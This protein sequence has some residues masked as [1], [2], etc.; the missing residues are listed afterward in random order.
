[1]NAT[2][3]QPETATKTRLY[4]VSSVID[5]WP[6]K[7]DRYVGV[8]VQWLV[9][10]RQEPV[11]PYEKCIENYNPSDPYQK[12]LLDECFTLTEATALAEHLKKHHDT[13]CK[14]VEVKLPMPGGDI[15]L[16][17]VTVGG[18]CDLHMLNKEDGY[19]LPFAVYGYFDIRQSELM[20]D[21]TAERELVEDEIPW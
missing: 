5:D 8:V 18:G 3:E 9:V 2:I 12:G 7:E 16:S 20:H 4:S 14:L 6:Y 21:C 13:N 17:Y 15:P 10:D 11:A 1:M 19:E